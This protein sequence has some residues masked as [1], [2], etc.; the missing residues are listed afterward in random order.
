[1]AKHQNDFER[2]K[3]QRVFPTCPAQSE[4][5]PD[6][7]YGRSLLQATPV[8]SNRVC[9]LL[10]HAAPFA[11]TRW[12]NLYFS[13]D[14]VGGSLKNLFGHWIAEPTE[15]GIQARHLFPHTRYWHRNER[16]REDLQKALD[17]DKWWTRENADAALAN[18]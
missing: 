11:C 14:C 1:M 9:K 18:R 12:T 13:K 4:G 8:G 17:L 15:P 2:K 7:D 6:Q 5:E 3:E 16:A 10:H